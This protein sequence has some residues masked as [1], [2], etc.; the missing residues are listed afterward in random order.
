MAED[1]EK[2]PLVGG[3]DDEDDEDT[4]VLPTEEEGPTEMVP[5]ASLLDVAR[6]LV[7]EN[8]LLSAHEML[9]ELNDGEPTE[10]RDEAARFI[11]DLFSN[12]DH[13]PPEAVSGEEL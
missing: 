3:D 1:E 2:S 5:R 9:I 11:T 8:F 6:V 12:A 7:D 4:S 13:F 10:E